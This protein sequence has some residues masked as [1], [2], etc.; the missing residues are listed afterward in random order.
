MVVMQAIGAHIGRYC[1]EKPEDCQGN[2]SNKLHNEFSLKQ[3]LIF[4]PEGFI[5]T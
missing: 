5:V 1:M 4:F 2:V 3:D